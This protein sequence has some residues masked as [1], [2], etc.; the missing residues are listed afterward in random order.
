M[1]LVSDNK[2]MDNCATARKS[3]ITTLEDDFN[4][5]GALAELFELSNHI[6]RYIETKGLE[7]N[8]DKSAI[9]QVVRAGRMITYLGQILGLLDGPLAKATATDGLADKLMAIFDGLDAD[10]QTSADDVDQ[11]MQTLIDLRASARKEKN[12]DLADAIRDRLS[13]IKITLEDRPDGT[14]WSQN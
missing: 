2:L 11:L 14:G 3:F 8:D 7:T 5:A 10:V 12:F 1:D 9:A 6:N 13:E 4:T